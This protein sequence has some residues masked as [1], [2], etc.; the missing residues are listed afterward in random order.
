MPLSVSLCS[1]V[2][3]GHSP[4]SSYTGLHLNYNAVCFQTV[5]TGSS[6][7]LRCACTCLPQAVEGCSSRVV[8]VG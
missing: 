1:S 4:E 3:L 5:Q 2:L 7:C 8:V 6:P